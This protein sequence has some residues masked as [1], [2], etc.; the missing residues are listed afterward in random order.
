[1][2][3]EEPS[4]SLENFEI[5]AARMKAW[6]NSVPED[7][8]PPAPTEEFKNLMRVCAENYGYSISD[9]S[10]N[11]WWKHLSFYDFRIVDEGFLS[12][13]QWSHNAPDI[14]DIDG[15]CRAHSVEGSA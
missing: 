5:E 1:M 12:W 11:Q 3:H 9:D 13:M 7:L 15:Y 6:I 4:D 14:E 10:I 8:N 2:Q